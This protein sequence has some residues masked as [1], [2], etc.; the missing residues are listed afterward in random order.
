MFACQEAKSGNCSLK[1]NCLHILH[2][3]CWLWKTGS[4]LGL[5]CGTQ[6][7]N[8]W[9]RWKTS[10]RFYFGCL[11]FRLLSA[12]SSCQMLTWSDLLGD[13][14]G[15]GNAAFQQSKDRRDFPN[16]QKWSPGQAHGVSLACN[17]KSDINRASHLVIFF[18]HTWADNYFPQQHV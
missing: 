2:L 8:I 10:N 15:P 5:A 9:F 18:P 17:W 12:P 6:L 13:L 4:R 7:A 14:A 11:A 3:A 16:I 1:T